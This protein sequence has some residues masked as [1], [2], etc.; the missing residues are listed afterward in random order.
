MMPTRYSVSFKD[1]QTKSEK[2][3]KDILYKWK[4]KES[5]DCYAYIR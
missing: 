3:K 4:T 1:T 5:R 2:M